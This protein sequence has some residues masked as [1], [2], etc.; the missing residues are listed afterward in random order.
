MTEP[1]HVGLENYMWHVKNVRL[2]PYSL[3]EIKI[4]AE[5]EWD[6]TLTF[7]KIEEHKNRN[8]PQIEPATSEEDH[9]RRVAEAE[10]LIRSFIT[11]NGL[12]TWAK[13]MPSQ[14][15]T[16]AYWIERPTGKRHFWEELTYRDP[17]NN[18]VHASIPGH[19]YDGMV[20]RGGQH[21][22][23]GNYRDGGRAEG[24]G[25]YL[26]EM[27]LQAGMLDERPR[28]K[29]LFYIAQLARILRIPVEIQMHNGELTLDQAVEKTIKEVPLMEEN[30]ARYDLRGYFR[31][32]SAGM[33]YLIGKVQF[34]HL[35]RDRIR[36]LGD[37]F[38]L[39]KFHD[40]FMSFDMIPISLI[41][42]E[43]TGLDDEI[44]KLW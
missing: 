1:A 11:D 25:F 28:T 6:R 33:S 23:R 19:Q 41:R 10:K 26:E 40:E 5:V 17:L 8:V 44:K 15:R 38:D 36:Q 20:H 9:A 16:D 34:E 37:E 29:E 31:R 22:I 21:P 7:L 30:L 43:M 12:L 32:P 4:I 14:F 3:E 24:W 27:L 35:L 42:W 13:D 2:M 18:H 39:G